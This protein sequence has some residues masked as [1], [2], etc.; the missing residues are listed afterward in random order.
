MTVLEYLQGYRMA[1]IR[2]EKMTKELRELE[3]MRDAISLSMDGAPHGSGTSDRTGRIAA[4][5]ADLE[6]TLRYEIAESVAIKHGAIRLIN[7]LDD[8]DEYAVLFGK[9][10][11]CKTWA[12]LS[13]ELFLSRNTLTDIRDRAIN[14]I[15]KKTNLSTFEHD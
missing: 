4:E 3:Q 10:I 9:Y 1:E 14:N 8:A 6:E 15:R 7:L 13:S 2:V 12:A 5:I 11:E